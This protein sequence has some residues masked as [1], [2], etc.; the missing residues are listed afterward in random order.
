MRQVLG[1]CATSDPPPDE[2][3]YQ[4]YRDYVAGQAVAFIRGTVTVCVG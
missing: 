2:D 3:D 4:T 1:V